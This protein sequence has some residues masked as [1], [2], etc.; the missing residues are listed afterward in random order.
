MSAL[1]FRG[2]TA[3]PGGEPLAH[4]F[5]DVRQPPDDATIISKAR[6]VR[7]DGSLKPPRVMRST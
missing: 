2:L 3:S 1:L 5:A 4:A 7:H 6:L